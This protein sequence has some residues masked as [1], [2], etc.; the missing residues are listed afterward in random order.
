[1]KKQQIIPF[2]SFCAE[3]SLIMCSIFRASFKKERFYMIGNDWHK[4]GLK[5]IEIDLIENPI[6]KS[7]MHGLQAGFFNLIHSYT[8]AQLK[9]KALDTRAA[10]KHQEQHCIFLTKS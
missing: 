10:Q 1:M 9:P 2:K 5:K 3:I 7:S 6:S 4:K 8:Y